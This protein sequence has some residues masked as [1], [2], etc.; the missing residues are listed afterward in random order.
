MAGEQ[1]VLS[2]LSNIEQSQAQA[3]LLTKGLK[4]EIDTSRQSDSVEPGHVITTEPAAGTTLSEGDTV[5]LFI[6]QELSD[7][8]DYVQLWDLYCYT[9][10]RAEEALSMLDLKAEY[11]YEASSEVGEGL[12]I[13]QSVAA[14][15]KVARGSVVTL[16]ISTGPPAGGST[17]GNITVQNESGSVWKC[18]A[19]LS[20]P[21]GYSGGAVRITLKQNGNEK[22]VY[23]G[24]TAFPY[25]L[26][27]EGEAGVTEG[28]AYI[29]LLDGTTGEVTS[30][31]E[32]P[33]NYV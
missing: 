33:G 25:H 28:T 22:T 18:D 15:E 7:D 6:S 24:T 21:A 14:N 30:T 27:V 13:S 3:F 5:T 8:S 29:Y 19:S 1:I 23:E 31:I 20:E 32:Y 2:D 11:Q 10:E 12:V 26:Q 17:D 9:K 16:V 4:C